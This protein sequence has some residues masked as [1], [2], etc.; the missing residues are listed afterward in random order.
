MK[1]FRKAPR[2]KKTG[3]AKFQNEGQAG[4]AMMRTWSHVPSAD[5][6]DLHTYVCPDCGHWHFG[7]KSYYAKELEKRKLPNQAI[8]GR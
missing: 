2:C 6:Y 7:H 1:K 4:K 8:L 3:K 5:I